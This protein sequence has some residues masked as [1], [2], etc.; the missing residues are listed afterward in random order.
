MRMALRKDNGVTR[1]K[2]YRRFIA[3][4]DKAITFRN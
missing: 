4:L 3:K 2:A 1:S